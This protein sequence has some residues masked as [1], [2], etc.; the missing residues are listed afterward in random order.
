M[1]QHDIMKCYWVIDRC[2]ETRSQISANT[3]PQNGNKAAA[4]PN[5][6]KLAEVH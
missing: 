5:Q 4:V 3:R 1:R 2:G 6:L